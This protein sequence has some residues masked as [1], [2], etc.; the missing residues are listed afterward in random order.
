[1]GQEAGPAE[2]MCAGQH[3]GHVQRAQAD[4]ALVLGHLALP[5]PW[6]ALHCTSDI[7]VCQQCLS[8]TSTY[9]CDCMVL[10]V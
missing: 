8:A 1:M 4:G 6:H 5:R 7:I 9:K 3:H 2:A 10:H